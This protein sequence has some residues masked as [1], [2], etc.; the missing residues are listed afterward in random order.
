[1]TGQAVDLPPGPW[2]PAWRTVGLIT[3]V[4]AGLPT[5]HRGPALRAVTAAVGTLLA[6]ATL[7]VT[8]V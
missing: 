6:A 2:L 5:Q 3:L 1:M 8:A 4:V 7:A